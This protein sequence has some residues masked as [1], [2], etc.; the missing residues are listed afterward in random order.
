MLKI[1]TLI[2]QWNH[3]PRV[4][5]FIHSSLSRNTRLSNICNKINTQAQIAKIN[6]DGRS[7]SSY[8]YND[9]AMT[10]PIFV[11]KHCDEP[12][13]VIVKSQLVNRDK[14]LKLIG[15]NCRITKGINLIN[16]KFLYNQNKE[17]IT[18]ISYK[19]KY[20]TSYLGTQYVIGHEHIGPVYTINI[21]H[22]G[23]NFGWAYSILYTNPDR[24]GGKRIIATSEF[25]FKNVEYIKAKPRTVHFDLVGR[26]RKFDDIKKLCEKILEL[27]KL[28]ETPKNY[29]IMTGIENGMVDFELIREKYYN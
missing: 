11:Q 19:K 13:L 12:E 28:A 9:W 14:N 17:K 18:P 27:I 1:Q 20:G 21:T 10:T 15:K 8:Q 24:H 4:A 3:K 5:E 22:L 26:Y 23:D 29:W 2:R 25:L 6:R 16:C 7:C